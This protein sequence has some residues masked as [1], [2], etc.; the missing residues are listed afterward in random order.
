M[1]QRKIEVNKQLTEIRKQI[2]ELKS[3]IQ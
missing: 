1:E 3:F 2:A